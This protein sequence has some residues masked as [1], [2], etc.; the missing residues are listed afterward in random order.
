MVRLVF[1]D[2]TF[3]NGGTQNVDNE[4]KSI[5]PFYK[6]PKVLFTDKYSKLSNDAKILY[7]MLLDRKSLSEKNDFNDENGNT[8]VLFSNLEVCRTIGCGHDKATAMFRELEKNKLIHR[9]RQGKGKP[10]LIY[11]SIEEC[12]KSANWN[13]EKSHTCTRKFRADECG[14]SA[15]IKIENNKIE[16]SHI[17]QSFNYH[18]AESQIKDQIEYDVLTERYSEGVVS[19]IV[20]L[21]SDTLCSDEE[22]IHIGQRSV[23][24]NTFNQR[25]SLLCAEHIEYVIEKLEKSQNK[26]H[27]MRAYM[28]TMLYNAI[29]TMDTEGIYGN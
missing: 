4:M 27:N 2:H 28:L 29:D 17:N 5:Q 14:K 11:V 18:F 12:E 3:A 25:I 10:D 8:V 26:I 23:S 1:Y 7:M 19:E 15:R 20:S 22:T 21:L 6:M 16:K 24:R 9:R 13:A